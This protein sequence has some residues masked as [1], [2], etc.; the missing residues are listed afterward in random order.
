MAG[1]IKKDLDF[2]LSRNRLLGRSRLAFP[3]ALPTVRRVQDRK[4]GMVDTE[5]YL[6]SCQVGR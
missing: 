6:T 5:T 2:E 1:N 4:G 3:K